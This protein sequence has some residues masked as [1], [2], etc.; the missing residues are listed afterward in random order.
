MQPAD[1]ETTK[2]PEGARD[3]GSAQPGQNG[4]EAQEGSP[5]VSKL[6]EERDYYLEQVQRSRAELE[7]FRKRVSRDREQLSRRITVDV[8]RDVLPV[9]DD[10]RLALQSASEENSGGDRLVDGLRMISSK[11]DQLLARHQITTVEAVG[12]PFDPNFHEAMFHEETSEATDGVV[13][14]EFEKGYRLGDDLIRPARVKVA[15]APSTES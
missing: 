11:F 1:D 7:N 6:R 5:D 4:G 8:F 12:Q 14:A 2:S 9:L 13:L 10:L 15:K 3:D